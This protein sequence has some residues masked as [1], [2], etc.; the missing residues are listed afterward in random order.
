MEYKRILITG[1]TGTVGSNLNF[2]NLGR[3]ISSKRVD[4][5]DPRAVKEY[6]SIGQPDAVIHCAA[7]VGGLKFHME[8][9]HELFLD[10]VLINTNVINAARLAGVKRVLSFLSSCVFCEK[11]P[12]PYTE[13]MIHDGP[14]FEVHYPYGFSKRA[15]EVHSRICYEELGLIYNCIIPTNIYGIHDDFNLDTGHV[16]GVLIH[17]AFLAHKNG[18]DFIVWGNGEQRREFLFTEDVRWLTEWALYNYLEKEPI[19]FSSNQPVKIKEVAEVIADRFRI[20]NRLVFDTS[21]PSGQT[22]RSL[23]GDKL[24]E[25][26][27]ASRPDS[28]FSF[29]P[30]D[31]G[32]NKTIDWFLENYPNIRK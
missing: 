7:K 24:V 28:G 1:Q 29:T 23:S 12:S 32:I 8:H 17:K 25:R 6:F 21:K 31:I 22:E 3:G 4:L 11:S 2:G 9:K 20:R 13:K 16:I 19:I 14:P 30:I 5:R 15:L 10:N 27:N 26:L 18:T